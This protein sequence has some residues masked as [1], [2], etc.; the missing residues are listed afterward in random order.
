MV[1]QRRWIV[2]K[3]L[4]VD[5]NEQNLYMLRVLLEGHGHEVVSARDG[6]EALERARRDP[7]DI[8]ITDIL[9]PVMDGFALCR[10]WKKDEALKAIP[11]VFYTATYTDS[12]D[13]EFAL[14][15]GAERFIVKPVE[16]DV[17]VGMIQGVLENHKAGRL[18]ATREPVMEEAVHYKEYSEALVRKLEGKMLQ[19][20]ETNRALEAEIAERKRAEWALSER[21]KE[22]TCLY[23]VNRDMRKGLSIDELLRRVIG[24]LVP[25]MQFPEITA[26]VVELDDRRFTSERYAE[27]LSHGLHAEIRAG[28]EARGHLRVYYVEE[29]PFLIP[30]EQD[31]IDVL[32]E[33]LG[34][35]LE[36]KWTEEALRESE[37]HFRS[38]VTGASDVITMTDLEGRILFINEAGKALHGVDDV[39]ELIGRNAFSI[40]AEES[41]ES[42]RE[43]MEIVLREGVAKNREYLLVRE[44]GKKVSAEMTVSVIGDCDGKPLRFIAITRDI[45]ERKQ[46][47]EELRQSYAKLR[48]A[49]EGTV[50]VLVS[51]IEM[52]DPYTAGHQRRVTQLACA[53]ANEMDLPEEQIEGLRMAALIHDV[54]KISVPAEVLSNPGQLSDFQWGLIKAHP[55]IGYEILKDVEFPWPVA[56][57]VLRHHER[58]NRS[59]YP[60]G[61][62]GEETLLEARILA[63]ADVVEAMASHRPYRSALGIDKALEEISQNRGVLYDPEVVNACLKLFAEKGF[64]FE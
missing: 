53:I 1:L 13:E 62:S 31:L 18:V 45:T 6:A 35:W 5:D 40:I 51:A 14:S 48:G 41:L 60:N 33:D 19:L 57:I 37:E 61:L 24:H 4:I 30:Y 2:T 27:G 7:P 28:G 50:N 43:G 38:L 63:V 47:E 23:A 59:G 32:A 52:R 34:L 54:G 55:Q 8:V 17:F 64:E 15:M 16:P 44:D 3:F 42:A 25:A 9:M 20:E 46:A 21:M 56:Q 58:I 39:N 12:K 29:R 11:F 49:L 22:L 26:P 10:E 36:R